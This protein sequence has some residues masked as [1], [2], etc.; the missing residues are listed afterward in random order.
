MKNLYTCFFLYR[1][2][3]ANHCI[4][5]YE[6][7]SYAKGTYK[8]IC[9]GANNAF[10]SNFLGFS[11]Y[12]SNT[13]SKEDGVL[14]FRDTNYTPATIPNPVNIT[15]PYH[16]RYVI[17]YNN[18]THPPYPDGYSKYAYSVLC[19][20]EVYGGLANYK[21]PENINICSRWS[22]KVLLKYKQRYFSFLYDM[23]SRIKD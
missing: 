20:V 16:C 6:Y 10:V 21:N 11:V 1:T 5:L 19:E 12:I 23:L 4:Y 14:R 13:T 9:L 2:W 22:E 7:V 3:Y 17:Y 18:R 15:C 8:Y